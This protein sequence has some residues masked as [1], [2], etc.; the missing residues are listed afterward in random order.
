MTNPS[1]AELEDH[2][3]L[4]TVNIKYYIQFKL[5]VIIISSQS[6]NITSSM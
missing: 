4:T 3:L 1:S 5:I 6:L 2:A